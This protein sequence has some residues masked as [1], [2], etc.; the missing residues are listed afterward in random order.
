MT[1]KTRSIS[2]IAARAGRYDGFASDIG[3][4]V[5]RVVFGGLLAGHGAQK[6]FGWFDGAGYT[7]N[8]E[9]F[10]AMGYEP[11]KF[12][13]TLAG[14]CEFGGGLLVLLGLATPLATA[15]FV[16]VMINAVVETWSG[17]LMT[18]QGYE[19][20]LMFAIVGATVAFTGPGRFAVDAGR[21]WRREGVLWGIGSIALA[22][23][24][25]VITVILRHVIS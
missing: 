1:E 19:M 21:S 18:G 14:L 20:P 6:L 25:S 17:G 23:V 11:G 3:L 4:L 15:I 5:L 12:F 2:D 8:A 10:Q 16:G 7:K 13:G 9:M 24:A 22:V